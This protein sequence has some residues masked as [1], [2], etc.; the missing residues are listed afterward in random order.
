VSALVVIPAD[1]LRALL[2]E[3]VREEL[4]LAL[5]QLQPRPD[6]DPDR[7]V[8]VAEA[9]DRLGLSTSTVYKRAEACELPSVKDGGRL[10]FRVAD[11]VA[12]AEARRRSSGRSSERVR[13]LAQRVTRAHNVIRNVPNH[14]GPEAEVDR[15]SPKRR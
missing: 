10:L 3:V 6:I 14:D 1:E 8:G 11:L 4:P 13:Q 9:A 12:Y 5:A 15:A 2:R 7:L